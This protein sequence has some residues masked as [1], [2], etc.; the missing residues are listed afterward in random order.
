MDGKIIKE[1]GFMVLVGVV[2][3]IMFNIAMLGLGNLLDIGGILGGFIT[4]LLMYIFS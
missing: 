4:G 2:I 1:L 3:G